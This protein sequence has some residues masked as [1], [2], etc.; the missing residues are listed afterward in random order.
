MTLRKRE[1]SINWKRK[2]W[3]TFYGEFS[4]EEAVERLTG[5]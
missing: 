3:I 4:L 2:H 5:E 1:V